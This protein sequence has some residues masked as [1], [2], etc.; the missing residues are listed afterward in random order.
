MADNQKILANQIKADLQKDLEKAE[1]EGKVSLTYIN[2]PRGGCDI[3]CGEEGY[4]VLAHPE[5]SKGKRDL[6]A[7]SKLEK[8]DYEE[9]L[10]LIEQVRA[11]GQ[12][13]AEQK[14]QEWENKKDQRLK[15]DPR[16]FY[17]D[18]FDE[19]WDVQD[20]KYYFF[21]GSENGKQYHLMIPENHPSIAVANVPFPL[22]KSQLSSGAFYLIEGGETITFSQ[23]PK[24]NEPNL[25]LK[26]V[27]LDDKLTITYA[28]NRLKKFQISKKDSEAN[29]AKA[30]ADGEKEL[31]E[32]IKS[33]IKQFQERIQLEKDWLAKN[34]NNLPAPS[35]NDNNSHNTSTKKPE[36]NYLLVVCVISEILI[37]GAATIL[38]LRKKLTKKR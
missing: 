17:Y 12:K 19:L 18:Y 26:W 28:D 27:G 25:F 32:S 30:E 21:C 24:S 3:P 11:T 15:S 23:H 36:N 9:I 8:E 31:I 10:S 13:V 7:P 20:E 33:D 5:K 6:I 22:R 38:L 35:K 16:I 1:K 37:I 29:L 14:K 34:D 2:R 4:I